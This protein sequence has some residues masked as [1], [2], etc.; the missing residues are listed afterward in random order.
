MYLAP[1]AL[2]VQEVFAVPLAFVFIKTSRVLVAAACRLL[3]FG[4]LLVV[5]VF[6]SKVLVAFLTLLK[7]WWLPEV[8][9]R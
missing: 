1:S 5:L 4:N 6:Q 8:L 3:G 7:F 2:V 9:T